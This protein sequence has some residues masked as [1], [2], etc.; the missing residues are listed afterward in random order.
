MSV[1]TDSPLNKIMATNFMN[2]GET[3][4]ASAQQNVPIDQGGPVNPGG[5]I[6]PVPPVQE[7]LSPVDPPIQPTQ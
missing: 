6:E 3:T 2:P 4:G 7:P 1:V 5:P